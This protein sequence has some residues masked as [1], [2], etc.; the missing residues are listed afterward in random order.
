MRRIPKLV[1]HGRFSSVEP[2]EACVRA[3]PSPDCRAPFVQTT[4]R[5]CRPVHGKRRQRTK[6]KLQLLQQL[7]AWCVS[8]VRPA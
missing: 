3:L 8:N 6:K 5:R 1:R 7:I 2:A 4:R